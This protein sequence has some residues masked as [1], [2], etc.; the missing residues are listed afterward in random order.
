M[1]QIERRAFERKRITRGVAA[2]IK[3]EKLLIGSIRDISVGGI[4]FVCRKSTTKP[5]DC[6]DLNLLLINENVFFR[7]IS[8][9]IITNDV[10]KYPAFPCFGETRRFGARF[11]GLQPEYIAKFQKVMTTSMAGD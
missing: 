9:T 2:V 5:G 7:K 3:A 6:L 10:N 8:C 1:K 11:N 4:A